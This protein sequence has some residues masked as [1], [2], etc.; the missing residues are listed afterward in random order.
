VVSVRLPP[1]RPR[2]SPLS[3]FRIQRLL[4]VSGPSGSGKSTFL[5]ELASRGLSA[6]LTSAL[7]PG[8][9]EWPQTNGFGI[10]GRTR[11]IPD[12]GERRMLEGVVLHYDIMRV[13]D[14]MIDRYEDDPALFCLTL[15]EDISVVL[16]RAP[17]ELLVRQVH[18]KPADPG[19]MA[20]A[21]KAVE[22][23]IR[24]ALR[25]NG[26]PVYRDAAFSERRTSLGRRYGECDF[27]DDSYA[28]WVS[29]LNEFVGAKMKSPIIHV[30]PVPTTGGG[31]FRLLRDIDSAAPSPA[32]GCR[33]VE[34]ES[35]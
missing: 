23:A 15:A 9:S 16:I 14:T 25:P 22:R 31:S 29:F 5:N 12:E 18:Q 34:E 2:I 28:S 1:F 35:A 30:Q 7:P 11:A 13:I 33:S 3:D 6:E 32:P 8:A 17:A 27:L 20:A 21:L 10:R 19:R 24:L 26:R 4:V